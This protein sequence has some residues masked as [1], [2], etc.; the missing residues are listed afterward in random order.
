MA[1]ISVTL[2]DVTFSNPVLP[3]AGPNVRNEEMLF[4]ALR[5]GAGGIV[6]KT[7]SRKPAEDSRPTIRKSVCGGLQNSETWS[8][9]PVESMLEAYRKIKKEGVPLVCSLGYSPEDVSYLGELLEREVQPQ[10]VEFSVHYVGRSIEPVKEVARALRKAVSCPIWMKVS[11]GFPDVGDMA[12]QMAPLVDG[13]V[14]INSLGPTLDFDVERPVPGLGSEFGQGWLS[15]PPILPLALWTVFQIAQA[16]DK[17]ICGV[18][19]V[20]KGVDAIK[21][22]MAGASLVQICSGAIKEGPEIYGRVAREMEEWL[23]AHGYA[24]VEEVRGLY[25]KNLSR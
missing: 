22:I 11:P 20:E 25:G 15:G 7:V 8:E 5:G 13:F 12:S 2:H 24:S 14:A 23:D 16:Q 21:F 18:G 6:T 9:L 3:A 19:G 17:P 4:R 1:D 10:V